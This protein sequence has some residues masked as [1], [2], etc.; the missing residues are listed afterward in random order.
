[1]I[2]LRFTDEQLKVYQDRL[3]KAR[4]VHVL[5]VDP[6]EPREKPGPKPRPRVEP[7][8]PKRK[9]GR[10]RVEKL[11]P[12]TQLARQLD[13]LRIP[14]ETQ[15]GVIP[16]RGFRADFL[17]GR[18]L[19]VEVDGGGW[20]HGRHHRGIGYANDRER[21]ALFMIAGFRVLRVVPEQVKEGK[22][23][24]WIQALIGREQ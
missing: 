24:A 7:E 2:H 8:T 18:T 22:A 4:K 21:D 14:Y 20:G 17:I 1:M 12:E 9:R 19:V 10:P 23:V 13:L 6:P 15:V 3:A 16:D 11:D 5:P